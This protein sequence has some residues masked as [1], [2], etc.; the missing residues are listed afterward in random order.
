MI[1][2]M[3]E[4]Q[5]FAYDNHIE[6][7]VH[8]TNE[9]NLFSILNRG[10]LSRK[11]LQENNIPFEYNDEKRLDGMTE[12]V[13][14]SITSPNYLMFYKYRVLKEKFNWVVIAF[15][16]QKI[17]E[18]NCCFYRANASCM[19]SYQYEKEER[20]NVDSF[21]EMFSDWDPHHRRGE[22]D[23]GSNETTNPQAEV[24]VFDAIPISCISR[25]VF[26]NENQL[27]MYIPLLS[28]LGIKGMCGKYFF[29]PRRDYKYWMKVA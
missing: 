1:N 12:A 19:D 25:V 2:I 4:L 26:Q 23:L 8:F 21:E 27:K 10:V 5:W 18:Y 28:K 6:E 14:L 24:L 22:L 11:V 13:S 17:L 15:N 9:R 3:N 20:Q 16:S 29:S 7:F